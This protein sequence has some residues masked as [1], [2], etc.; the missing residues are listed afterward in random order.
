[1]DSEG[2]QSASC[3][4]AH[5]GSVAVDDLATTAPLTNADMNAGCLGASGDADLIKRDRTI[6]IRMTRAL[7][8][9]KSVSL[10]MKS[11]HS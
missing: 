10:D 9:Q 6:L 3:A 8:L 5:H 7:T 2:S 11:W 1:M 4:E